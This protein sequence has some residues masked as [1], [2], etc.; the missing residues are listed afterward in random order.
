MT[1]LT[2]RPFYTFLREERQFSFLLAFFLMQK[3]NA[4]SRF[5]DL[6]RNHPNGSQLPVPAPAQLHDAEIY[7]EYA[8][9]RDRWDSFLRVDGIT[10]AV[11]PGAR[12]EAN[13]NKKAFI[14]TLFRR[15]PSLVPL[16]DMVKPD[17]EPEFNEYFMG[18]TGARITRDIASPALWSVAALRDNFKANPQVFNKQVFLDLCKL[19]W[20]FRI[21]PDL[22]IDI[23]GLPPI[24]VEA[25]LASGEGSYPTG[26]EALIFD[27]VFG[28]RLQRVRQ[29]QLQKF[30]FATLLD[31][32][33]LPV[34][35]QKL[36]AA[37][38]PDYPVLIWGEVLSDLIQAGGLKASIPFVSKLV[39]ENALLLTSY[40]CHRMYGGG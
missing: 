9:L 5:L 37:S 8:Y 33:C 39:D 18:K 14:E 32:P 21:K 6:V 10:G 23:P 30:M 17:S 19:K 24:C 4:L 3:G 28:A 13:L 11:A 15:I 25:K 34:V 7:V 36:Y 27:E 40:A 31:R 1:E 16:A 26:K 12:Q 38:E 29:F 20:S 2:D 35:V 22:V